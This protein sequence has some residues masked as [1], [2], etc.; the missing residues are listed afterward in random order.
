MV[1]L[2]HPILA[3]VTEDLSSQRNCPLCNTSSYRV[4]CFARDELRNK[5]HRLYRYV[6][7]LACG[8]VYLNPLP[9]FNNLSE[10]YSSDYH[11]WNKN[12]IKLFFHYALIDLPQYQQVKRFRKSGSL[13]D[14]GCGMGTFLACLQ[15]KGGWVVAGT[16]PSSYGC[17]A[18]FKEFGLS[19]WQGTLEEASFE[20]RSFDVITL[21]DVLEHVENPRLLLKEIFR[22]LREDGIFLMTMPNIDSLDFPLFK[23]RWYYLTAPYHF[24]FFTPQRL[25]SLLREEGFTIISART[26]LLSLYDTAFCSV[27]WCLRERGKILFLLGPLLGIMVCVLGTPFFL[28]ANFFKKGSRIIAVAR[29]S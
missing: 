17:E 19:L 28:V 10:L 4:E 11:I 25:L 9:H 23:G 5:E 18:A 13:L 29:K 7:C 21:W 24:S 8:T 14:I 16:E 26:T 27:Q 22:L 2:S 12:R 3:E 15:G 1:Q 6:K 20:E